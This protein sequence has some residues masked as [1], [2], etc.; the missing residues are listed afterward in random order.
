MVW[1]LDLPE[2]IIP[3]VYDI[4][5]KTRLKAA[6]VP[7]SLIVDCVYLVAHMTGNRRSS[8]DVR[9]AA[10]RVI[11]RRT[12]PFN[13]DRRRDSV[14]WIEQDWAKEIVLEIIPDEES[15]QDFLDR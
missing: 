7:K 5:N 1:Q 13:Q 6:R 12:K 10:L 14:H 15:F 8:K 4:W 3:L 11:A 9:D 2:G